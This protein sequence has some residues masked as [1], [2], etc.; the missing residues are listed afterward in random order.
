VL[1]L[2]GLEQWN[3][4]SARRTPGCPEIQQA[5]FTLPFCKVA[6][7]TVNIRKFEC[8]INGPTGSRFDGRRSWLGLRHFDRNSGGIKQRAGHQRDKRGGEYQE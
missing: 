1:I 8:W 4:T 2:E 7:G 5:V 6:L 3:F